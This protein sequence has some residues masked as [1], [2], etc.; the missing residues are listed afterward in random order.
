MN[1]DRSQ[2]AVVM[3]P[4]CHFDAAIVIVEALRCTCLVSHSS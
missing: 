2:A 4:C 1:F 3:Q